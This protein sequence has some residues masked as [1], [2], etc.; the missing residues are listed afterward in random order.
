VR[1]GITFRTIILTAQG[2]Y[3][4]KPSAV[5]GGKFPPVM[6]TKHRRKSRP[7]NESDLLFYEPDNPTILNSMYSTVC[8]EPTITPVPMPAWDCCE[9]ARAA[10]VAEGNRLRR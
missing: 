7:K 6:S 3:R 1:I 9:L 4:Q 5:S 2:T 10:T 8:R